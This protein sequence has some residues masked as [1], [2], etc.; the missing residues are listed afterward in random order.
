MRFVAKR[1]Y[2]IEKESNKLKSVTRLEDIVSWSSFPDN[3][4]L[5]GVTIKDESESINSGA[6]IDHF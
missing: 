5:F 6:P 3:E 2:I 1:L 4:T